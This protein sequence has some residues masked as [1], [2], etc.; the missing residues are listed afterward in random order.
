M[1][2]ITA[3]FYDLPTI[4]E[5]QYLAYRSEAELLG[6]YDI[7]PLKQTIEEIQVEYQNGI[8]L[9]AV[10]EN[11]EIQGS[12]RAH[13]DRGTLYIGKLMVHPKMQGQG[14]GTQLLKAMEKAHPN[15]RYELFTSSKSTRNIR[16]YERLGYV[17]FRT[18]QIT[19]DLAFVFLEKCEKKCEDK[20]HE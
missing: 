10:N 1:R 19:P 2:I 6:S 18:Q 7:P 3:S 5:L 20:R 9:K 16:L 13:T 11:D 8:F 14:I 12:V 15:M 4:L 17:R